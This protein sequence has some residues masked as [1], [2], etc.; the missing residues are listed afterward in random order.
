MWTFAYAAAV[1]V[2]ALKAQKEKT[3][4]LNRAQKI[5]NSN[6][7]AATDVCCDELVQNFWQVG[8]EKK[9]S[10]QI[11]EKNTFFVLEPYVPVQYT[12]LQLTLFAI[13]YS[14]L[15]LSTDR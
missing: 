14:F 2:D 3:T 11:Q 4:V 7:K 9:C 8:Q 5:D 6:K 1:D 12:L 15:C 10:K 13:F